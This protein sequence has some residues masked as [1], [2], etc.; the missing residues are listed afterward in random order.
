[1]R[2]QYASVLRYLASLLGGL[3]VIAGSVVLLL[4]APSSATAARP[5]S[6]TVAALKR[7]VEPKGLPVLTAR[8]F[9][10]SRSV[11]V[12]VKG[13]TEP[14]TIGAAAPV[15]VANT[16]APDAAERATGPSTVVTAAANLRAFA[17]KGSTRV[18]VVQQGTRVTVLEA[19]RG[20]SRVRAKDGQT[21]WLATRF[22]R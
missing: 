6:A 5:E 14:V 2:N 3:A 19:E 9:D 11:R 1:M 21:G 4:E 13:K 18:G 15:Q 16:A 8:D 20:W 12:D 10:I 17:N 7:A 22:L